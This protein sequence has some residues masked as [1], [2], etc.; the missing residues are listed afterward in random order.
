MSFSSPSGRMPVRAMFSRMR[1]RFGAP[2]A[3]ATISSMRSTPWRPGVDERC[4]AVRQADRR[5]LLRPRMG[6]DVDQARTTSLPVASIVVAASEAAM[7]ASTALMRPPA[8]P[9]SRAPS[10][11][12]IGSMTRPPLM[13]RSHVAACTRERPDTTVAPATAVEWRN[14]RR[15][16]I[17]GL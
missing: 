2:F 4:H 3:V 10:K 6:V 17:R 11:R 7:F 1:T 15:V 5:H 14:A 9:T 12:R 8:I 13:S 16:S